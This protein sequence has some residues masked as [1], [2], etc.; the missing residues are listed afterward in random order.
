M[1]HVNPLSGKDIALRDDQLIISRTDLGGRI[2]YVNSDFVEISGFS[3]SELLG[4]PHNI[5]RHPEMPAQVFADLWTDLKAERPWVGVIHNRC[6]NGDSY[7]V[8]AHVSPIWEAGRVVGYVSIRRRASEQQIAQVKTLYAAMRAGHLHNHTFRHGR[9]ESVDWLPRMV[10]A[11]NRLPI[12]YRFVLFSFLVALV[13]LG[14]LTQFL[15]A[16]LTQTLDADARERLQHKVHL[17]ASALKTHI[18]A[19]RT[20]TVDHARSFAERV[21]LALL[22]LAQDKKLAI[23]RLASAGG[24]DTPRSIER[25]MQDL[26]SVGTVFLKTPEGYQRVLSNLPDEQAASAVG[27]FLAADHPAVA[28]LNAGE[29]FV[30]YWRYFGRPYMT[31]YTPIVS[32]SGVVVGATFIGLNLDRKLQFFKAEM[33]GMKLGQSGYYYI[34]DAMEG[35]DFGELILHPFRERSRVSMADALNGRDITKEMA[36]TGR[37]EIRYAWMNTEAGETSPQEKLVVFE[38][39]SEPRWVVAGGSS[40]R[41][42][43]HLSG[44]VA[45]YLVIA[46]LSMVAVVFIIVLLLLRRLVFKPLDSEVLPAFRAIAAGRYANRLNIQGDNE[47]AHVIQ[48]LECMQLRLAFEAGQSRDLARAREAARLAAENLSRERTSFLANMSHEIRTPMNAV[49]GFAHLLSKSELGHRERDFVHRI[50]NAGKLLLGVVNDILDFSKIDAGKMTLDSAPFELDEVLDNLSAL[51]RERAQDKQLNLEYVVAPDLPRTFEGD[52]LRLS[53]VLINL[54]GNAIKFTDQGSVTVFIDQVSQH[55]DQIELGFRIQDTGIGMSPEQT[56]KLF[57]AF[58]QADTSITRRFGG[59]GLGLAISKRLIELMGGNIEVRSEVSVGSVFS[60][61]VCLRVATKA[62]SVASLHDRRILVVDDNPL[63]R[64]VLTRLLHKHAC[65]VRSVASGVEALSE[66]EASSGTTFDCV[67]LDLNM[68]EMD[69]ITLAKRIRQQQGEA[70]KL[71]LVTASNVHDEDLL[72]T[73]DDFDAVLE[74][75]VTASRLAQV[76]AQVIEGRVPASVSAENTK[77]AMPLRGLRVLVAED[78]P[79]NQ[80]IIRE[81][82]ESL[83]AQVK[84]AGNGKLALERLAE[85]ATE[86]DLVLMD[87]Q[88]PVMDGLE[89]TRQI[90]SGK[91]RP[92]IPVIALTAHAMDEERE[93]TQ[94][95]GM[96]DF[97]T[98]PIDP[99]LLLA[100][101]S[102]WKPQRQEPVSQEATPQP[103]VAPVAQDSDAAFPEIPGIDIQDGL[104]RMRFKK[105]LYEKVLRD[106]H[107]RF[108]GEPERI[109]A[110]LAADNW[111]EARRMA[112]S[113]KGLCATIGALPLA[114]IAKDLEGYLKERDANYQ[115][116]LEALEQALKDVLDGIGKA[117]EKR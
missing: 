113:L 45:T 60:F 74:K 46:G 100:V 114:A 89:A 32:A 24:E 67:M 14:V 61:V 110:A 104:A 42:F 93:R 31:S 44:Y 20:E 84:L 71:I 23:E 86:T 13:V 79:T 21:D 75:P 43:T 107:A 19:A 51:V 109:R 37:G 88:M 68:P 7:W 35:P 16:E 101:L 12:V 49:I 83:G 6:K 58:S 97:V 94:A 17:V 90:R 80:M 57:K 27:T 95:A 26:N 87:I 115:A 108:A 92:D 76:L 63:A 25:L 41:E 10:G 40:I 99:E 77:N 3:E 78:V 62:A 36:S 82:L 91:V 81:L 105:S 1:E 18:D 111:D 98:K 102:R 112:H 9:A 117:F 66:L 39:L 15:R 50:E 56:E 54:V 38:T 59:T 47:I 69:G 70:A 34:L 64:M 73:L 2:V 106:F 65:E 55:D 4:Q 33:R 96:N 28:A 85:H 30:G 22:S 72:E 53:Q 48:G 5:I 29:T 116:L 103:P 8:L 52:A 11:L